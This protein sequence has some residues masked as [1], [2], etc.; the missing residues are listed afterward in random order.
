[1]PIDRREF[2]AG[3]KAYSPVWQFLRDNQDKAFTLS[4]LAAALEVGGS[5]VDDVDAAS[6][7]SRI[8]RGDRS[9]AGGESGIL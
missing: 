6:A 8:P 3:G 2:E 7:V 5:T 4:E 9:Q 1:M